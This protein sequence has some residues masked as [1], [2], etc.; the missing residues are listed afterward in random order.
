MVQSKHESNKLPWVLGCEVL[1]N[2]Y[3]WYPGEEGFQYLLSFIVH[4]ILKSGHTLRLSLP[5]LKDAWAPLSLHVQ[6]PHLIW[7]PSLPFA[8]WDDAVSS[9]TPSSPPPCTGLGQWLR[10]DLPW[11]DRTAWAASSLLTYYT[12]RARLQNEAKHRQAESSARAL[13]I[14]SVFLEANIFSYLHLNGILG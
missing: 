12:E 10:L 6:W 2:A 5:V 13:M 9:S 14:F 8:I 7:A 4:R 1:R 11:F 3:S